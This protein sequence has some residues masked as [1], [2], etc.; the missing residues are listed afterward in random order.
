M[1]KQ[2]T[3][4][5]ER[6]G[7]PAWARWISISAL[8]CILILNLA[9]ITFVWSRYAGGASIAVPIALWLLA[10]TSLALLIRLWNAL[11]RGSPAQ[12]ADVKVE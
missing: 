12:G 8:S 1:P 3:T 6:C 7:A 5:L 10:F 9:I 11:R 4:N 2:Y